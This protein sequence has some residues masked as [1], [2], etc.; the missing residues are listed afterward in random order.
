Y[1]QAF[2]EVAPTLVADPATESGART[3]WRAGFVLAGEGAGFADAAARV[4][5][6]LRAFGALG[7]REPSE[8]PGVL[9][10]RGAVL[11]IAGETVAEIGELHPR[12]LE[13]E[14]VPVP[15]AYGEIDLSA[16]WPLVRSA[17]SD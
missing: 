9:P 7:V 3:V 5:A 6:V 15:V 13:A 2:A 14:R 17:E 8:I 11:R 12:I 4:D 16:L 10:G 1:P